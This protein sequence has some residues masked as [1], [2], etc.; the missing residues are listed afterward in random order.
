MCSTTQAL[1]LVVEHVGNT[2]R[3]YGMHI[4]E[5]MIGKRMIIQRTKDHRPEIWKI[6]ALRESNLFGKFVEFIDDE[7]MNIIVS[8]YAVKN[9][10]SIKFV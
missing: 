8:V 7:K 3:S 9:F 4:D 6:R 5:T 10:Y 2:S 1:V